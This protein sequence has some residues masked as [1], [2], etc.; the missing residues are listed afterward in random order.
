M[1][2]IVSGSRTIWGPH[3]IL[4]CYHQFMRGNCNPTITE[5]VGGRGMDSQAFADHYH[6][7]Y[8]S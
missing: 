1:K 8:A 5:V 6:Y 3:E 2:L 7:P 4:I